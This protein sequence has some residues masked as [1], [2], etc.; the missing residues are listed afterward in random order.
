[1]S[2]EPTEI[3]SEQPSVHEVSQTD[4]AREKE[5]AWRQWMM[6][7]I[8][9]T[10]LLS[11]IAVVISI[12]ALGSSNPHSTMMLGQQAAAVAPAAPAG[13]AQAVKLTIRSDT[14]HGRKGPDGKWHDA[15]LPANFTVHPGATVTVTVYNYDNMPHSF[16]SSSLSTSALINQNIPG[17]SASAPSRTTFTFK[18]PSTPGGYAWWCAM[19]CDPYAMAHVGFMRGIV[20][21]AA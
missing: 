3:G 4:A 1:M 11:V 2:S 19:P 10:A 15:F 20:T 6:V 12:S 14:E 16:T 18:A 21:V 9:W 5:T 13:P 7:G 17:G 8:G